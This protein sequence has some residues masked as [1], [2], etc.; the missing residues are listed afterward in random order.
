MARVTREEV[1]AAAE[2]VTLDTVFL[3][4]SKPGADEGREEC[5]DA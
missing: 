1:I 4:A 2:R 3:L 5:Q